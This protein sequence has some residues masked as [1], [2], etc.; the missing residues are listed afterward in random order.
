MQEQVSAS[1][2]SMSEI[3]VPGDTPTLD[4]V[5][6]KIERRY[7]NALGAAELAQGSVQGRM[8]EIEQAGVQMAG[9][10]RLEQIRASMPSQALSTG[11]TAAFPGGTPASIATNQASDVHVVEKSLGQ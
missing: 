7:V 9:H 10:L 2:R 11:G 4:E 6:E 8:I 3:A 1:L 5:R